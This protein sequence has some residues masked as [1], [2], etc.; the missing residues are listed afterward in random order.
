MLLSL[1]LCASSLPAQTRQG[2]LPEARLDVIEADATAIHAGVGLGFPIGVYVRP[3][4]LLAAGPATN[5]DV[6]RTS[7][8]M[9]AVARFL[10]DPLRESSLGLYGAGGVSALHDPWGHWRGVITL[11][12]GLELPARAGGVWAVEV[13]L[14]GGVRLGVALRRLRPGRR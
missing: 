13:G 14:G 9:D 5:G 11:A 10:L 2:P 3:A 12:L 6:W 4:I 7:V 1:V 8:R